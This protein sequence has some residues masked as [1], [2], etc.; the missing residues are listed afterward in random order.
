[1][2]RPSP[3]AR[4]TGAVGRAS[5]AVPVPCA[6]VARCSG[7]VGRAWPAVP[8]PWGAPLVNNGA[9]LRYA[10]RQGRFVVAT[11]VLGSG[12]S[13][14]DSTVV[15][16]ALPAIGKDFAA[17]EAGLQWI[18]TAYLLTLSGLL[19]LGGALGDRYGRRRV[20]VVGV[21]WFALASL[22]CGLAPNEPTLVA[23][24]ALQGAG[25]ALLTPGSLAILEA[26][27]VPEDRGRAIGAWT[28]LG[29]LAT[30]VGPF[31]GG[32]LIDAVS[33]RLIFF[34][35]LPVAAAVVTLARHVPETRDPVAPRSVDATGGVLVT[36][37]LVGLTYGLI[38]GPA[39]GWIS[40]GVLAALLL[41][42]ACL[43]AFVLAE[44]RRPDSLVPLELFAASQF[45]AAN[46]VTFAVYGALG[47]ALFLLPVDLEQVGRY[48]PL[49]AGASLLPITAC[50]L[51]LSPRFGALATRIG[52]RLQM[53]LGPIVAAGGL[54]LL[55][56]IGGA[57]SYPLEVLP[58]MLVFGL[59]LSI[60]VAP[61]TATVLAAAPSRFSAIASAVNNDVAR[62]ASLVAVAVL[63]SAAG[64]EGLAYL[65]PDR[66]SRGFHA[67]AVVCA[68]CCAA[69]GLLALATIRNDAVV[70]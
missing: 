46:A 39:A 1:M 37:G 25:G 29:G 66:F 33:W 60:T 10:S 56:R 12:M 13:L 49:E 50:M 67:A 34:V 21:C 47:G 52:P 58:S 57:A 48:T 61:L 28:G 38:E 23:A 44:L 30:A 40:A 9:V 7:A 32:W 11:A 5:P 68:L 15:N 20:F 19:L 27:F 8:E 22:C 4:C 45:S 42:T 63:P 69:G 17:S 53:G 54:V 70:T 31:L 18:V 59:G 26:V 36:A 43:G 51:V 35:N 3:V 14:L 6:R 55:V 41:G 62:L 16:I 2:A 65:H 64:L 24:R